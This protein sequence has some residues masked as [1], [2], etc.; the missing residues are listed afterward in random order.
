MFI[1]G[2]TQSVAATVLDSR[3]N[4]VPDRFMTWTSSDD[5]VVR[6]VPNGN[7]AAVAQAGCY[8]N[9]IY[10]VGAGRATVTATVDGISGSLNVRVLAVTAE[11]D[12]ISVKFDVI[13]FGPNL[14]APLIEV[15]ETAGRNDIEVIGVLIAIP[16]AAGGVLGGWYCR[17]NA[18]L[19]PLGS[20]ALFREVYGDYQLTISG[21]PRT[22]NEAAAT[23]HVQD[24]WGVIGAKRVTTVI[25]AGGLPSTYTGGV[26]DPIWDCN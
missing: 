12:G 4:V 5:A 25:R 16:G 8:R 24:R 10:A 22:S 20:R 14:Y 26:P 15:T 11:A 13:E 17:G 1:P 3:L 19:P 7:C 6:V 18:L 23:V 2:I 9:T 21:N